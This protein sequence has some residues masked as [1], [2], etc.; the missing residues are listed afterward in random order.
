MR[1]PI[2]S[3]AS[4]C[5]VLAAG[6]DAAGTKP[7]DNGDNPY[8]LTLTGPGVL[9]VSPLDT[10]TIYSIT[11]LGKVAPPGHVL[12]TDHIYISFVDAWSGQQQLN[13]CSARP[14]R[15]AGAGV[16][17]FILATEARGDT[18]VDVQMTK[19][20][21]YYYD[22]VLLNAGMTLGKHVN[23]GDTIATTTGSCPSI[24]LGVWDGDYTPPGYVNTNRY[25]GQSLHVVPPLRY[26]S[27]PLRTALYRRVRLFE[28]VPSD[29]DGRTDWGVKGRLAGDWFHSSLATASA[30]TVGGPDGWP[31]SLSFLYDYFSRAPLLSV[32]GTVSPALVTPIP[33]AIGDPAMLGVADG[34]IA[35]AT[36][37]YNGL[38]NPGWFLIQMTTEDRLR[39]EFFATATSRPASFT[40]AAQDY[41]R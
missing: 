18:K 4:L 37:A 22:H 10:T 12:P 17:D 19:T 28:G 6:C 3:F 20:F 13:D 15:A 1:R 34:V 23:A 31:K 2:P 11:P 38:V 32:G 21:H 30:G 29:K 14:V 35:F 5:L 9:S 8:G 24:D 16:I 33:A 36:Q 25:A 7:T 41:V 39:I 27:E 40:S 26:F